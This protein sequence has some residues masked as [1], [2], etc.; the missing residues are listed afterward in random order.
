MGFVETIQTF[1]ETISEWCWDHKL[2][3]IIIIIGVTLW[4]IIKKVFF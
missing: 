4:L 2:E 3:I 1:A